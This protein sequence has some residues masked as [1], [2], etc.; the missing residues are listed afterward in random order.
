MFTQFKSTDLTAES[1]S[2][3]YSLSIAYSVKD[4]ARRN[5]SCDL[6]PT[7]ETDFSKDTEGQIPKPNSTES[8][9]NCPS[10]ILIIFVAIKADKSFPKVSTIGNEV[11]VPERLIK[12]K[13]QDS[14]QK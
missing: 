13:Q 12:F 10:V 4:I 11:V 14:F 2:C 3:L 7:L 8:K 9:Y 1:S 6:E 5:P